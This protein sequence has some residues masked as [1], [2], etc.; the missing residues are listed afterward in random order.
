MTESNAAASPGPAPQVLIADDDP[1]TVLLV[2]HVMQAIGRTYETADEGAQAWAA[3]GRSRHALVVLDIEMPHLDGLE[4]CRRIRAAAADRHTFIL[5]VTVRDRAADL[6]AVLDAGADDYVTK[7]VTGQH[8]MARVRIAER[9]MADE[10]SRREVEEELRKTRWLAGIG[11]ATV[12]LQHEI[13]NP[14]GSLLAM[15]ELIRLQAV[16]R[17]QVTEEIDVV[18]EQGKRITSVVKRIGQLRELKS[19]PYVGDARMLGLKDSR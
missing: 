3:W 19:I 7:P 16:E 12:T 11:E 2:E 5:I 8:L 6:E 17:G 15:A 1:T 9:R 10:A 18:I 13:N 4:I 14:L